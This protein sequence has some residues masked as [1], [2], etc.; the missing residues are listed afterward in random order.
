[1][2]DSDSDSDADTDTDADSDS[3]PDP[4]DRDPRRAPVS[5]CPNAPL[6]GVVEARGAVEA[7]VAA[8]EESE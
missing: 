2:T 3:D 8:E 4:V 6:P 1:M 5:P 7:V